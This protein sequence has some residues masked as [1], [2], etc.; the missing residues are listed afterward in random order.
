M[1]VGI[2]AWLAQVPP[3]TRG[4]LACA[5]LTSLA[6]VSIQLRAFSESFLNVPAAMPD[7]N[8]SATLL[9]L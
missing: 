4:W 8:T 3:V 1:P 2:E 5:V 6:V 7:D 9:Q